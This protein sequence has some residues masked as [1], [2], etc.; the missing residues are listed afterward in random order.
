ML[1]SKN[2]A[3]LANAAELASGTFNKGIIAEKAAE[4]YITQ[5]QYQSATKKYEEAQIHFDDAGVQSKNAQEGAKEQLKGIILQLQNIQK[6]LRP[7]HRSM[8]EYRNAENLRKKGK[9]YNNEGKYLFAYHSYSEAVSLYQKTVQIRVT[10]TEKIHGAI[11]GYAH[12][13]ENKSIVGSGYIQDSY[14]TE[15]LE[16]WQPFFKLAEDIT[17]GMDIHDIEFDD[18]KA[19]VFV[20]VLMDYSGAGGSGEKIIWKFELTESGTDW[21]ISKISKAN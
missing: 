15:L 4:N 20:D 9:Q 14:E 6:D 7:Q 16:E 2:Q 19:S 21:L 1:D 3:M 13:L 18:K 10:Q 11:E 12:A 8:T 5:K 17:I